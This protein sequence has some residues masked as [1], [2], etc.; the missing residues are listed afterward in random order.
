MPATAKISKTHTASARRTRILQSECHFLLLRPLVR[1]R[2]RLPP[3]LAVRTLPA[4][5]D[6]LARDAVRGG[7]SVPAIVP[8]DCRDSVDCFYRRRRAGRLIVFAA[9]RSPNST[10]PAWLLAHV[11]ESVVRLLQAGYPRCLCWSV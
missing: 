3:P 6:E 5:F 1:V 11:L 7:L 10:E 2:G 8:L 4:P 9:D